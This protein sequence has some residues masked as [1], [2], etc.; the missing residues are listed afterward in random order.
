MPRTNKVQR[1]SEANTWL[2]GSTDPD[3]LYTY[4]ACEVALLA[5]ED[6]P[7]ELA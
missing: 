1:I 5:P 7:R 3:W 2:R 4:N 6:A